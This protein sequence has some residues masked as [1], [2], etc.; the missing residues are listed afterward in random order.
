M[1]PTDDELLEALCCGGAEEALRL[2]LRAYGGALY[3]YAYKRLGDA[4]LAEEIVQETMLRVWQNAGRFDR[5]AGTLRGWL[6]QIASNLIVDA[7]RRRAVRPPSALYEPSEVA[8]SKQSLED[9]MLHWQVAAV[10]ADLRPEHREVITLVHFE[11][12][13][14]R[15]VADQ[16]RIPLGTVKSRCFYAL[17][18]LRVAL[19]EQGLL[20]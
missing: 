5:G 11:G 19:E 4:G 20:Q 16:L 6:Y 14:L 10:M 7:Q 1:V 13:K 18:S 8:D 9:E 3:G 17:E 12:F 2:L 15:E